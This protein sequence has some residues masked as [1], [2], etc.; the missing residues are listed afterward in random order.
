MSRPP[1]TL[2]HFTCRDHSQPVIDEVGYLQP[3]LHPLLPELGPVLWLTDTAEPERDAVG[4]TSRTCD[5]M[6]VRYV[7]PADTVPGLA[8]W[9]ILRGQCDPRVVRDLE[10]YGQPLHWWV[11]RGNVPLRR[12]R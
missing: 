12:S 2:Y 8:W 1:T 10:S 9:P 7:V 4:L 3:K 5:R 11:G 6:Q